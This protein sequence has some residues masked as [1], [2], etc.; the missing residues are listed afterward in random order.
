M[1]SFLERP[2]AGGSTGEVNSSN[3]CT[4]TAPPAKVHLD[5]E[6]P[7]SIQASGPP[8]RPSPILSLILQL[9]NPVHLRVFIPDAELTLQEKS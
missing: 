4:Q 6:V 7:H 3:P 2:N 5:S 1:P 9:E 8:W